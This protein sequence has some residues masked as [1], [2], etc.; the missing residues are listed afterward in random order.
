M[1]NNNINLDKIKEVEKWLYT[2]KSI[3]AGIENL[4]EQ[5]W[6]LSD[7]GSGVDTTREAVS[8]TNKFSSQVE[9]T[10]M[11]M[12]L[13]EDRILNMENKIIQVD[14]ALESLSDAEREVIGYFYIQNKN[15]FEFTYK[16]YKSERTCK[17][18]KR[19]ALEKLKI[20]LFG[21]E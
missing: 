11:K 2:Y 6:A 4:K 15:Y 13:L 18:I 3:Q 21:V 19:Q 1:R 17:R 7:A 8:K 20:A 5:L 14:R 16:L 10:V 9:D 12:R